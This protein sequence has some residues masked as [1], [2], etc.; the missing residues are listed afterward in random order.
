M[1]KKA[2]VILEGNNV[3]VEQCIHELSKLVSEANSQPELIA[4]LQTEE[5]DNTDYN[6]GFNE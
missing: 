1:S 3:Q 2:T 6:G 4:T 5:V